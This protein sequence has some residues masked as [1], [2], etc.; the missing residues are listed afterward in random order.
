MVPDELVQ[1]W[2][3]AYRRYGAVSEAVARSRPLNPECARAMASASYDVAAAWRHISAVRGAPWWA[4]A[5]LAAAAEA[6][7]AQ[8]REWDQRSTRPAPHG[9]HW[10]R[11]W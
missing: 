10:P 9:A 6:F 3:A 11:K 5:A 8:A 7:E 2:E 1:R 4:L